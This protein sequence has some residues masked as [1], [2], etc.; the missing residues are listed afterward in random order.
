MLALLLSAFLAESFQPGV[1][2]QSPFVAFS[3]GERV[4]K[5]APSNFPGLLFISIFRIGVIAM[6][7]SM[8]FCTLNH[9]PYAAFWVVAGLIVGISL[10]KMGIHALLDYTFQL[11]R[12]FGE[13]HEAYSNLFTVATVLLYPVVLIVLHSHSTVAAVWMVGVMALLFIGAWLFRCMRIYLV[14]PMAILYLLLYAA[15]L[16][17]M[18]MMALF[19]LSEKTI[20]YL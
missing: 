8:C 7:L 13:S 3:R 1:I 20:A 15:T 12:R 2:S 11:S 5:D 9:T 10:V 19:Y 4:Y 18:P 6:A 14:S 16:E 17:V